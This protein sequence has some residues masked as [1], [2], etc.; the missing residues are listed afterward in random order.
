MT[1]AAN[2]AE[3]ERS[4]R[5]TLA[6]ANT[7]LKRVDFGRLNAEARTQ[8]D[9]ANR[10]I[11][12]AEDALSKKNLV[13]AEAFAEKGRRHRC[14]ARRQVAVKASPHGTHCRVFS[15]SFA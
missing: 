15:Y 9:F 4:I 10:Y 7:D 5:T 8:Y 3:L 12:Q 6:R 14:S 2:E 11:Q 13:F 1:P